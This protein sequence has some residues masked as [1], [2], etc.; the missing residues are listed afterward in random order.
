MIKFL[1]KR[2][3]LTVPTFV[4]LMFIT[5][6]MIRLVPGDPIEVRR[7]ERGISPERLELLRHQMGLDQPVWRQFGD[8]V[9]GIF[10]GDLGTSI[11]SKS[12]VLTE[13]LTLFPATIELTFFAMLI[14]VGIGVPAGVFAAAKR[15]SIYDQSLMGVALGCTVH[16]NEPQI[17]R[18]GSG[19]YFVV[20]EA[21][22]KHEFST[23]GEATDRLVLEVEAGETYF[24][25]RNIGMGMMSG[26]A[27]LSPSDEAT[28]AKKAKGLNLWT[29]PKPEATAAAAQ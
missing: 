18:L 27:N 26:R 28:F 23:R 9:W 6:V 29:G 19:K 15:G 3:L 4:A 16:E 7:G 17:A 13:F 10:H 2:L 22:G 1:F 24:V 14:A 20:T 8:Y 12:P 21:P 5:F 25:K 11:I